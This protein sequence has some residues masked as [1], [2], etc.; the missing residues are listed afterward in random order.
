MLF[1][2][3][4]K[5]FQGTLY[6]VCAAYERLTT[7][8]TLG[9]WHCE[10][11]PLLDERGQLNPLRTEDTFLNDPKQLTPRP[12]NC[13]KS[14]CQCVQSREDHN[15]VLVKWKATGTSLS[16]KAGS[17]ASYVIHYTLN[18][19]DPAAAKWALKR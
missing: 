16:Y 4:I 18:E 3:I 9:F 6:Q 11:V 13:Q 8:P 1:V 19:T 14:E 2:T 5:K 10:N 17:A 12:V 15:L 7:P